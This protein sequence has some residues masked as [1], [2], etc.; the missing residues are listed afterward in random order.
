MRTNGQVSFAVNSP[1]L[2][3][4]KASQEESRTGVTKDRSPLV[5]HL[6]SS[7]HSPPFLSCGPGRILPG[8]PGASPSQPI[9]I[10]SMSQNR[11][12]W[13]C[14]W[15]WGKWQNAMLLLDRNWQMFRATTQP[16][17]VL[18]Q[19]FFFLR[20]ARSK[21]HRTSADMQVDLSHIFRNFLKINVFWH[22]SWNFSDTS[23]ILQYSNT[24]IYSILWFWKKMF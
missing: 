12:P 2:W 3:E 10:S 20:T 6:G 22:Q 7:A 15:V 18:S 16:Q 13:W 11:C 5:I 4:Y 23:C 1:H 9:L 21:H 24:Y 17:V 14:P 19:L 8:S